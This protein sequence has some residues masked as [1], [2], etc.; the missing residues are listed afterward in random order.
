MRRILK[1]LALGRKRCAGRRINS[2]KAFLTHLAKS[3]GKGRIAKHLDVSDNDVADAIEKAGSSLTWFDPDNATPPGWVWKDKDSNGVKVGGSL[4][5]KDDAGEKLS[6]D[7]IMDFDCIVTT[8]RRDRDGDVLSPKGALVDPKMPLL[9]QH[10]P[11]SPIGK[12][13]KL[14][15]QTDDKVTARFAIL[16]T[17]LGRDAAVLVRGGALRISHGF[18]PIEYNPLKDDA[19]KDLGGWNITKYAMME[20]SVVSIPS[21]VDAEITQWQAGKLHHPLV[22]GWCAL[23]NRSRPK[24]VKAGGSGTG[25]FELTINLAGLGTKCGVAAKVKPTGKKADDPD[26]EDEEEKDDDELETEEEEEV[27][28]K[29]DEGDDDEVDNG[30]VD[31]SGGTEDD[32]ESD[33]DSGDGKDKTG[34]ALGAL[35]ESVAALAKDKNQ[36][37]EAYNR[38]QVVAGLFEDI[39]GQFD[40]RA[41]AL[42]DALKNRDLAG[43]ISGCTELVDGCKTHIAAA[44]EE[45]TRIAGIEGLSDSAKSQIESVAADAQNIVDGVSMLTGGDGSDPMGDG[46]DNGDDESDPAARAEGDDSDPDE[47]DEDDKAEDEDFGSDDDD[48]DDDEDKADDEDDREEKEGDGVDT[49]DGTVDPDEENPGIDAGKSKKRRKAK[50]LVSGVMSGAVRLTAGE[51]RLLVSMLGSGPGVKRKKK[52]G[53]TRR[54]SD[55]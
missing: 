15:E 17:V 3:V 53:R 6:T 21:N 27:E 54:R 49:P 30:D 33:D 45:L 52:A 8:G 37:K 10:L 26:P 20:T 39:G 55:D 1:S 32:E 22:K 5:V 23:L 51:K 12:M 46:V 14:L 35:M 47:D 2:A 28:E 38:L 13:V 43:L 18:A 4:L 29:D 36:P 50:Q 11:F 7:S 24:F 9:W 34:A 40:E 42:A 19:G 41:P 48:E 16:D 31:P 25:K 44:C